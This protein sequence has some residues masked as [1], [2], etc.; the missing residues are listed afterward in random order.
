MAIEAEPPVTSLSRPA[1]R[2]I[3]GWN[4]PIPGRETD[5]KAISEVPVRRLSEDAMEFPTLGI[6]IYAFYLVILALTWPL[7]VIYYQKGGIHAQVAMLLAICATLTYLIG[8]TILARRKLVLDSSGFQIVQGERSTLV[9]WSCILLNRVWQRK[10]LTLTIPVH[11]TLN[12][13]ASTTEDGISRTTASGGKLYGM[14]TTAPTQITLHWTYRL[15]PDLFREIAIQM[16]SSAVARSD[17]TGGSRERHRAHHALDRLEHESSHLPEGVLIL[18]DGTLQAPAA[19]L[20]FPMVCCACIQPTNTA[21]DVVMK[22]QLYWRIPVLRKDTLTI[23]TC[24]QCWTK[25]QRLFWIAMIGIQ[26]IFTITLAF[27]ILQTPFV[28]LVI[29]A[30]CSLPAILLTVLTYRLIPPFWSV[31]DATFN[32]ATSEYRFRSLNAKY[33]DLVVSCIRARDS[34]T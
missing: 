21:K 27:A 18:D 11:S 13:I 28:P 34:A 23:P 29:Y 9:P 20:M 25:S 1:I 12:E 19:A 15:N 17:R 10:G 30:L 26:A 24:D 5:W 4:R 3:F 16:A 14:W 33:R 7:T 2:W 31:V 6:R 22:T 8:C 32:P